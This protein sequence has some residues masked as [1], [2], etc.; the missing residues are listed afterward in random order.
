[1][2]TCTKTN[3]LI[4]IQ[5]HEWKLI[6]EREVDTRVEPRRTI[7][8]DE[9]NPSSFSFNSFVIFVIIYI[10]I[11]IFIYL[12]A[13]WSMSEFIIIIFFILFIDDSMYENI[14]QLE[15]MLP[16][17]ASN[18]PHEANLIRQE[19][20]RAGHWIFTHISQLESEIYA[21]D[22]TILF[23]LFLYFAQVIWP[24]K[25]SLIELS[26]ALAYSSSRKSLL[27]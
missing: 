6:A 22:V 11:Y 23:S 14:T 21:N 15:L 13:T 27:L 5:P 26:L 12:Y 24:A 20:T 3:G 7:D 25:A 8:C 19:L 2:Q 17:R 4:Q 16:S 10:I 9:C 18:A 1:L